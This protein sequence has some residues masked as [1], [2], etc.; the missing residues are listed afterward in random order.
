MAHEPQAL[1]GSFLLAHGGQVFFGGSGATVSGLV[2][3]ME[4][5][6]KTSGGGGGEWVA[7]VRSRS[8]QTSAPNRRKHLDLV[9]SFLLCAFPLAFQALL[10]GDGPR[11][12]EL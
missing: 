4:L 1:S 12:S 9:A 5:S 11:I 6:R 3:V 10:Q 2:L 8:I 7:G